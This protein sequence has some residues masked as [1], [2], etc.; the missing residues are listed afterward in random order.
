MGIP[1]RFYISK[2]FNYQSI[3]FGVDIDEY[4]FSI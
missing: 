2:K 4:I 3:V 1:K